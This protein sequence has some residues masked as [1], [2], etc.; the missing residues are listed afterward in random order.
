MPRAT[1]L[2][3]TLA[4]AALLVRPALA[5]EDADRDAIR[6]VIRHQI[7]A[8]GR[9]D[10]PAAYGDASPAIREMFGTPEGFMAMVRQ[11][12]PQVYRPKHYD[13]GPVREAGDGFEQSLRID[14]RDGIGWDAIYSLERQP[15]GSWAISGCRLVKAPDRSV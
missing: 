2:V 13:F 14:D 11:G 4:A 5:I 15:D 10:G 6:G 9:D 12:Y 1:V 8:F 3:L 7:E